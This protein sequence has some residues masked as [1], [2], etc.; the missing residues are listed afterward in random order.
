MPNVM[1]AAQP[2][3]GGAVCES[4]VIPFLLPRHKVWLTAAARV[5]CSNGANIGE[6]RT[7]TQS[8]TCSW[9]NSVLGQE[10]SKC[11]VY[12]S[13]GDGQTFCKILLTSIERRR[14][15]KT[16]NRLKF[17]GVAQTH[18]QISAVSGSKFTIVWKHLKEI[19]LF[20][21]FFRLSIPA[22]AANIQPD[23][24][25]RWC[26]NGDFCVLYL[27]RATCSTFQACILNSH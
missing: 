15:S 25:V 4:S 7:W 1:A 14:C 22:L 23:K 3:I 13:P 6:R 20:N 5:P 16:R 18:Q 8:E 2:N 19:L 21:K 12:S 27:Q 9:Q 26:Q 11:I 17:A 10:P 24:V